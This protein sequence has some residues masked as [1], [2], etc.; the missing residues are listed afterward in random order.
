MM[1]ELG[2]RATLDMVVEE[3]DT[4]IAFGSGDVPVLATPRLVALL[5][6][7]AVRALA[8]T[9][10]DGTTSV[11]ASITVDHLAASA[12]GRPVSARAE[13]VE[14]DGRSVVFS[15]EARDGERVVARG[16]HT[17][18][19]VDRE[20]FLSRT[21]GPGTTSDAGSSGTASSG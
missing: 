14:V 19:V 18:A 3:A 12:I 20:G 2:L 1:I 16:R 11:G 8:D 4:A 10:P 5:E 15:L 21:T 9:L 7:A 6:A 13:V 17:R